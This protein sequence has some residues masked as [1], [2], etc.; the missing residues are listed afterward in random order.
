MAEQV[1]QAITEPKAILGILEDLMESRVICTMEYP[2]TQYN[3]ITYLLAMP[4]N[5]SL[6]CLLVDRVRGFR[7]ALERNPNRELFFE[8]KDRE[9]VPFTF[10]TD[11]IEIRAQ[12]ILV[13][14]PTLL[15][16]NQRRRY[17]RVET[18]PATEMSFRN[19]EG[20]TEAGTVINL[21]GG[22]AAFLLKVKPSLPVGH[23]LENVCL[24]IPQE[25]KNFAFQIPGATIRRIEKY[26]YNKFLVAIEF[27]KIPEGIRK[28]VIAY[29]FER[30]RSIIRKIGH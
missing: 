11:V 10:K 28:D 30:Q 5:Q 9:R 19:L 25:K 13:E 15:Q 7:N 22:G 8:F 20:K 27:T 6:R 16:R 18:P 23:V 3:W 4:E 14:M 26:D 24:N 29:V 21:S 1:Y 17:F 12:G 2:G